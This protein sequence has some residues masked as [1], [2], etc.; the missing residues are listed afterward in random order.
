MLSF[1][2]KETSYSVCFSEVNI[3]LTRAF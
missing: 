1:I 3:K 2:G